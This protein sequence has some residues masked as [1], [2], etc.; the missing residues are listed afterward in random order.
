MAVI[1]L[2][3][4]VLSRAVPGPGFPV[5]MHKNLGSFPGDSKHVPTRRREMFFSSFE[6]E[7]HPA[8]LTCL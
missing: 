5:P 7:K 4:S 3:V 8:S 1:L 2:A 6:A